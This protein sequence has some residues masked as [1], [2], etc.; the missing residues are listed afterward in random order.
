MLDQIGGFAEHELAAALRGSRHIVS[1]SD[2]H[3]VLK[4]QKKIRMI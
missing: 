1:L 3:G 2:F 4:G